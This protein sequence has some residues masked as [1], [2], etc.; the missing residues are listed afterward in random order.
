M[1]HAAVVRMRFGTPVGAEPLRRLA[2]GVFAAMARLPGFR[3]GY[4]VQV[5]ATEAVAV[6]FW[7]SRA[8]FKRA[9]PQV[10]AW[11]DAA[12]GVVAAAPPERV[13]GEVVAHRQTKPPVP[14]RRPP[15]PRRPRPFRQRRKGGP[16]SRIPHTGRR[17]GASRV[18]RGHGHGRGRSASSWSTTPAAGGS[19]W[20]RSR[21]RGTRWRRRPT[22]ATR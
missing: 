17:V 14:V 5:S 10:A 13:S 22:A 6:H 9:A 8:A 19:R 3:A 2:D 15:R 21:M 7:D 4:A 16:D 1:Y 18:A 11:A 20:A 12:L